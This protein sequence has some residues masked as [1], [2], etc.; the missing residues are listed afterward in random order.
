MPSDEPPFDPEPFAAGI[1][2]A[3]EREQQR[4]MRRAVSARVAT[5]ELANRIAAE[6]PGVQRIYLFGSLLNDVPRNPDFDID[7][8]VDG[9]DVYAAMAICE[10]SPYAVDVVDMQRVRPDVASRIEQTGQLL[11]RPGRAD[12]MDG[13]DKA[14]E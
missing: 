12:G 10:A 3:N 13:V 1:R 8:A 14:M 2:R 4:T 9:G 7:L 11:Y 5:Q 6:V